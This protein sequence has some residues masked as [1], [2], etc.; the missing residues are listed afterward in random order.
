MAATTERADCVDAPSQD[1]VEMMALEEV[2]TP[3][4]KT[5]EEVASFL[6]IEKEQTIK[7]LLFVVYDNEGKE[8]G[9]VAA[10]IR[11]DREL[12]MTKL[13]NALNVPEH[14]IEFAD[15]IK[16]AE[17]TGCVGGFTGPVGLK[18][19]KVVVDSELVGLKNLCAGANKENYHL[20]NVN[21]GRDY[22]GDIVKDLS[23]IHICILFLIFFIF[24]IIVLS[25]P[26]YFTALLIRLERTCFILASSPLIVIGLGQ[27]N[28]KI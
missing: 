21:Y 4:T 18:N 24:I 13:V 25:F 1:N 3:G 8:N 27:L 26:Q 12:N 16:M 23:L 15:E 11:G 5:I 22:T 19:C 2:N 28:L 6:N 9:Y 10:F 7:A 14:A 20:K 17:E